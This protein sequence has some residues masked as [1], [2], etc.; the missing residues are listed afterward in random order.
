MIYTISSNKYF[1]WFIGASL[2]LAGCAN[3]VKN[4]PDAHKGEIYVEVKTFA[5]SPDTWGYEILA[6]HKIMIKQDFIPAIQGKKPFTREIDAKNTGLQVI[7]N[8]RT[9]H[10]PTVDSLDLVHLG[11]K[12]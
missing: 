12:F 1:T 5:L 4:K 11:V 3:S 7:K 8:M 9:K 2:L 10:T 6:D